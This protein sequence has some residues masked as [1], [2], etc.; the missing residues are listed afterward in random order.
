MFPNSVEAENFKLG[1][2]KCSYFVNFGFAPY[3]SDML[4]ASVQDS[5]YYALSFDESLNKSQQSGQMDINVRFWNSEKCVTETRYFN[6]EFLGGA[7][8][9]AILEAFQKATAKLDASKLLQ[10]ASDGPNVN[11]KFLE[12]HRDKRQFMELDPLV[13]IGMCGLHTVHGSLKTGVKAANWTVGNVL[14]AMHYF[15]HDSPAR[16]ENFISITESDIMPLPYCGH[17]WCENDKVCERAAVI[18]DS[19]TKFLKYCLTVAKSKQPK[20][21]RYDCLVAAL[22]DPL[23]RAKFKLVEYIAAK[24]NSFLRGFQTDQPMVPFPIPYFKRYS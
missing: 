22:K 13:D 5:P 2:T 23:I 21:K 9:E 4:F 8:A 16:K 18:W 10:V 6:S 20:G 7:K 15:L 3:F 11:L 1:R 19:Y 24:L 17:R 14:K 12:L